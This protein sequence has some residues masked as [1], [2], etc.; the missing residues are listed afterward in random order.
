MKAALLISLGLFVLALASAGCEKRGGASAPAAS[1]PARGHCDNVKA[2][3]VCTEYSEEAFRLGEGFLKGACDATGGRFG[4]GPCPT[5]ALLGTCAI[6]GGQRKQFY[7]GGARAFSAGDA[8]KECREIAYG[9][10]TAK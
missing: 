7:A 2:L 10:W 1:G 9:S 3:S 6:E 4:A 5:E 8:A